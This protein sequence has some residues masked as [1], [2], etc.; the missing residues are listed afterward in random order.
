MA[1]NPMGRSGM[2]RPG[3]STG[4][5]FAGGSFSPRRRMTAPT[6]GVP[7]TGATPAPAPAMP[8]QRTGWGGKPLPPGQMKRLAAGKGLNAHWSPIAQQAGLMPGAAAPAATHTMPDGS[9]MPGAAHAGGTPTPMPTPMPM[10]QF[11][12]QAQVPMPGFMPPGL[13]RPGLGRRTVMPQP[14]PPQDM[15][16]TGGNPYFNEATGPRIPLY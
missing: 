7:P 8:G 12:Q 10:G 4:S 11:P 15:A 14:M 3:P 1:G 5:P 13:M 2:V 9:T 16:W 6:P